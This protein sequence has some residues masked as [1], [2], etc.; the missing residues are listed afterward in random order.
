MRTVGVLHLA[1]TGPNEYFVGVPH[2]AQQLHSATKE[3]RN[4]SVD[5]SLGPVVT[6]VYVLNKGFWVLRS[7]NPLGLTQVESAVG[8][9]KGIVRNPPVR[10]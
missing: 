5:F 7:R 2:L 1:Q 10:A 3:L 6:Q 8:E 4:G 9:V